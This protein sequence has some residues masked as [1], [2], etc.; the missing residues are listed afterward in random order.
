M[1]SFPAA[2][3]APGIRFET[4]PPPLAEHLP[5]MDVAA[6]FGFAACGPIDVPVA[7]EDFQRFEEV[8]GSE[9][10]LAWNQSRDEPVVA[11]LAPTV[12]AFFENGGRRCW[13][14][15]VAGTAVSRQF[16]VSS[17]DAG[18]S[19]AVLQARSPGSWADDLV[20]TLRL[21]CEALP[22]LRNSNNSRLSPG[23]NVAMGDCVCFTAGDQHWLATPAT[24]CISICI[25][26]CYR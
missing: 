3:R 26:G 10:S 17:E 5:R 16:Q 19:P 24:A 21:Q 8:F 9:F 20:V 25:C 13:V 1:I 18:S 11:L 14:I 4:Q 15:R 2:T 6:F 7:V 12:R 23:V 22:I